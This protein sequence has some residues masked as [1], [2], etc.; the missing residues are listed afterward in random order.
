LEVVP[1]PDLGPVSPDLP[2]SAFVR[3]RNA[4]IGL[5]TVRAESETPRV[6]VSP[7]EVDVPAGPPVRLNLTIPIDGLPGGEHEAAVRLTS[8]GGTGRAAVRFRL[9]VER[10][11]VPSVV[12]LGERPA[13][14]SAGAALSVWNAGTDR[15]SLRIRGEHHWVRPGAERITLDPGETVLMP[16]R[17]DLPAGLQGPVVSAIHL[18]GRSVRY[19]VPVRALAR[20]VELI[21]LPAVVH[22][23]DM[24]PGAERAFV[25]DVVNAGEIAVDIR[26]SHT[27]GDLEVWV[28]RATV[29]PGER[30]TLAGRVRVNAT[31]TAKP[32]QALVPLSDEAS[33][34]CVAHVVEPKTPY[35][36]A[37]MTGGFVCG[38][39]SAASSARLGALLA[40]VGLATGVA[41]WLFRRKRG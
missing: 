36:L 14:R 13:G 29:R 19:A 2:L 26:E 18:E 23:G 17:M 31:R 7:T 15:V 10:I 21:V 22:L 33:L 24:T 5:L 8:N 3:V 34:R 40:L 25:V 4:G 20:K 32:V 16:F 30:I 12:D 37:V 41:V 6:V 39:L 1:A 9:P 35:F 28:R 38:V 11:D 27:P